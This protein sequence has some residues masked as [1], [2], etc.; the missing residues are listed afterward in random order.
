MNARLP[1]HL[2]ELT[3]LRFFA[4]LAVVHVHLPD[5]TFHKAFAVQVEDTGQLGVD[6]FFVLSGFIM[7]HAY[8]DS[9]ARPLNYR[10]FLRNR[11]ARVLP[12]HWVMCF[13]FVVVFGINELA[14]HPRNEGYAVWGELPVH[15]L[16]IHSLG[17]TSAHSWNFPSWSISAEMIAYTLLPVFLFLGRKVPALVFLG[18]T[19]AVLSATYFLLLV[20]DIRLTRMTY[21]FG[22]LRA[23]LGF[24]IGVAL[25]HV[26]TQMPRLAS[27][28]RSGF[29]IT[30]AMILLCAAFRVEDLWIL[31]LIVPLIGFGAGLS[32]GHRP[33]IL[34]HPSLIWLGERSYA[35]YMVHV[36]IIVV[37]QE[38][39]EALG[40]FDYGLAIYVFNVTF[41]IAAAHLLYEY[42]ECPSR[43]WLRASERQ[44]DER[45]TP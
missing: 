42:V 36:L 9:P 11:V 41:I 44:G 5:D 7:A 1:A 34:R 8:P 33:T 30:A 10:D 22:V 17:I 4:A 20:Q 16:A 12:L 24:G 35:I 19:L 40:L 3:A 15:I 13:L 43:R 14:G 21:D 25:L 23:I 26:V 28:A 31:L 2:H 38:I 37:S 39:L 27:Y 32:L 29:L 45:P 18:S 6:L